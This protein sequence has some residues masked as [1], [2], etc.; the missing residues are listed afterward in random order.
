MMR[1]V[2]WEIDLDANSPH[3]AARKALTIQR[4][5]QSIATVFDVT[6]KRGKTVRVD[7][8]NKHLPEPGRIVVHISGGAMQSVY[9]DRPLQVELADEDNWKAEGLSP[10][11]Q[12]ERLKAMTDGL[13]QVW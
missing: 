12:A 13:N 11:A 2:K 7:L 6:G 5:P 8:R 10:S 9:A 3:E 4:N 1:R